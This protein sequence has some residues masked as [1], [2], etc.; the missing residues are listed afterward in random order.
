MLN[1]SVGIVV[2]DWVRDVE[3]A[4]EWHRREVRRC[5]CC[6]LDWYFGELNCMRTDMNLDHC[7]LLTSIPPPVQ[8]VCGFWVQCHYTGLML[9]YYR[10]LFYWVSIHDV[11]LLVSESNVTTIYIAI[12][13][14]CAPPQYIPLF[15]FSLPSSLCTSL[16]SVTVVCFCFTCDCRFQQLSVDKEA[17]SASVTASEVQLQQRSNEIQ[18]LIDKVS[19]THVH[20]SCYGDWQHAVV[21][22]MSMCW[23]ICCVCR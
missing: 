15:S 17:L 11:T 21:M 10:L 1:Q 14:G 23:F 18:Q 7:A 4:A 6:S 3:A 8:A 22:A 5:Q 16:S 13:V 9:K 2:A 19:H 20:A 12:P